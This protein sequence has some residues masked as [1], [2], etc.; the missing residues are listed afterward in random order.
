MAIELPLSLLTSIET[1]LIAYFIM[2]LKGNFVMLVLSSWGLGLA[3]AST[4]LLIGCNIGNAK[5]VQEVAPLMFVPQILFSG[6]FITIKLIPSW[7]QWLQYVCA[8][9]YAINLGMVAEFDN[10]PGGKEFLAAQNIDKDDVW[11]YIAVLAGIFAG[12]RLLAMI[13]LRKKATFVY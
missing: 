6:I 12:F 2:G 8:L 11:F 3:G 1:W 5:A 9:K 7:L 13:G 10:L 4:A